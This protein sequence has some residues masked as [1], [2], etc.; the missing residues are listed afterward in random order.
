MQNK[1]VTRIDS[2]LR[3][4][5][6]ILENSLLQNWDKILEHMH[7]TFSISD[8]SFRTFIQK[9]SVYSVHDDL[10]TIL[11]DD[12]S[13]GDSKSFI[14]QK[15]SVFLSV[16]IEEITG[17]HYQLEFIALSELDSKSMEQQ[18]EAI[19][20]KKRLNPSINPNYT[21]DT[22]IVGDN[23]DFAHAAS[24]KVA[25]EPGESINPLYIYGGAGLGKTHLMHAIA[26]YILEHDSSKRV[27][28]VTSET[29]TNEI[30]EAVRGSKNDHSQSLNEFRE[31][32]RENV[33]V[34]LIDDIQFIIGK[35]AT[36]QEFF[37]TFSHLTDSKKQVII[38]SD[39]HPSTMTT[40]D[41]RYR[42]RFEM[43]ITVDIKAPTY[44][45]R[46]AILRS[47]VDKEHIQ[48]DDSILDYIASNIVSNIRELQGAI[49]KV[50]SF[51]R[52]CAKE[53]TMDL[54]KEALS[55]K[56]N[57]NM[58]RPITIDYIIE[59]VA[60]HFGISVKDILS[61]KRSS[62]I[63]YPRHIC[64]YICRELT[65]SPLAEIGN[66]LGNRHHS[67]VLHSIEFI[68]NKISENDEETIKNIDV[69]KKKIDPQ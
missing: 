46:M 65:G 20:P 5:E 50:I 59:T 33:D 26:N 56:I 34:L 10:L 38:S 13:I 7:T 51:S 57:P 32:Y 11:I 37:F 28:Y 68:E 27:V 35:E 64:M 58:K 21:F 63:A 25:E 44:E 16:S 62:N 12:T 60:D 30:V 24:L 53:I 17:V 69:L 19:A 29:F 31:K 41:E 48:I 55:D 61:N 22:F 8:V 42:S 54:A 9:L 52:L 2:F 45:T 36:Q 14:E 1:G 43:G 18:K 49:N 15:Y 3:K 40:L 23:N 6:Y 4:E 39:K 47:K 67:T 66:K